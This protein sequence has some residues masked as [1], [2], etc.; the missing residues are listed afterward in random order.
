MVVM[1]IELQ[2][3]AMGSVGLGIDGGVGELQVNY[4]HFQVAGLRDWVMMGS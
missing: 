2:Y 3:L 1:R 4:D